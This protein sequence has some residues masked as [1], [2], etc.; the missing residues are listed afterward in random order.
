MKCAPPVRV[1]HVIGN[2]NRGGAE[3]YL[4]QVLRHVDREAY[5]MDFLTHSADACAYGE[6]IRDLGA[7]LLPCLH[8]HRP[9]T[10]ARNFRRIVRDYGPYDVIHSQM[11]LF[12]GLVMRLAHQAGIPL[13]IAHVHEY[14]DLKRQTV[15][16]KLYTR[17]MHRWIVKYAQHVLVPSRTTLESFC[18]LPLGAPGPQVHLMYNVVDLRRFARPVD[19]AA[20]RRSLGLPL[21]ASLVTYVARFAPH[22]NHVQVLRIARA[23]Q[24]SDLRVHFVLAGSHG[25]VMDDILAAARTHAN[26]T[27]LAGLPDVAELLLASDLFLFPSLNEGFGIVAIEAAA[28]GLPVVATRMPSIEEACPP[29]HRSLMFPPDDDETAQR[30]IAAVL[31]D[32]GLRCRLAE[33]ARRWAERFGVEESIRQL[34]AIYDSVRNLG[35]DR[36]G[37]R[38]RSAAA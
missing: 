14:R 35:Q 37:G 5:P 19:R 18:R 24:E 4:M 28:A 17:W 10:Y 34:T 25:E 7:R 15:Y 16:R 32:D 36:P 31:S 6:E 23:M 1:L 13:R 33:D 2:M 20:V 8:P 29:S 27:V 22:K 3:T 38:C 12:S 26:V 11:N 21:G 30:R 9:W